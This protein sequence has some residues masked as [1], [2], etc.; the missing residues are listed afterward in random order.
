M[1]FVPLYIIPIVLL[2]AVVLITATVKILREYERAVV[3]TLGR[4]EKVKGPGLVLLIPYL[5]QMVRVDLRIQVIEIPSQDV[6]SRD[7]VSLKV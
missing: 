6:I 3:F 5:Q 1:T 2:L 7:N 4:F